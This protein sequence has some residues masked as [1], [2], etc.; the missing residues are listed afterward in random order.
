MSQ[1]TIPPIFRDYTIEELAER[2]G[3]TE[4]YL[5]QMKAGQ[6]PIRPKFINAACG[7]LNRTRAELF[8]EET[9]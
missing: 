5:A 4:V 2:L 9:E 1:A 3:D 7:I 6:K 8:G